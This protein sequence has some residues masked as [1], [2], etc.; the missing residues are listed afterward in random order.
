MQSIVDELKAR[1]L[2]KDFSNEDEVRE[3][4]KTK[5]TI[6]CGFDPSASSMHVGN[7]VMISMLMRLQ[8]A[9]HKII[10]IVG[11][12][13]GMI[14]DPSGKSKERN[15]QGVETLKANT[16]KIKEQLE[17]FIDLSDP[18]KGMILNNYEWLGAMDLLTYLRDYG[19]FFPVNYML[20]KDIVA[21]R[22]EAGV[23]YT[24]FSYMILQSIDFL[25]LHQNY[26]C[27]L[28]IGGGDQWGNLTSGLELIRKIEGVD[29]KVGCFTVPLLLDQNGK[30]FGKSEDGAL[31]LDAKLVSPYK[32]YQYF[33]NVS[34]DDAARYLK[35]FSFHSLEEIAALTKEHYE[36]LGARI[37]QKALAYEVVELIHGKAKAEECKKM[38]EVLFSGEIKSLS[39]ENIEE[40]FGGFKVEQPKG[41]LIE[42][43]LIAIK[44]ASSKREAREFISGNAVAINGEKVCDLT[45]VV[46]EKDAL[47]GEYV[48]I[49]RG[50]KNYYL[51]KFN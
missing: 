35:V 5:Q 15:L 44:A 46:D 6:Y 31:F 1:G 33:I 13:T 51:V 40:L 4:L 37:A 38:S 49:K 2:V 21:S 39:K 11:G 20:S 45:H 24:E 16:Q 25:K 48:V 43:L 30:K 27:S 19:K 32:I 41:L 36:H 14:G 26:G 17:R 47:F 34:D 12:A 3:L 42:D 28:Q 22:L 29:A 50:K 23:S 18:E 9:G 8:R 10:A 7:F